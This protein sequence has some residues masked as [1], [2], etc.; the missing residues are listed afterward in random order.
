MQDSKF[1]LHTSI[2]E[3]MR[4]NKGLTMEQAYAVIDYEQELPVMIE[5]DLNK[6]REHCIESMAQH[7]LKNDEGQYQ[8]ELL[9]QKI[10]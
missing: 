4:D 3:W 2:A 10:N 6:G 7:L 9:T 8:L 5:E 1:Y